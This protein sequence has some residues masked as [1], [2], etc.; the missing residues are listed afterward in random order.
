MTPIG[1]GPLSYYNCA[2]ILHKAADEANLTEVQLLLAHG[3][4]PN[5]PG[6]KV[7]DDQKEPY[8]MT[9]LMA[10]ATSVMS[11]RNAVNRTEIVKRLLEA[12]ADVHAKDSAGNGVIY[13]AVCG[14]RGKSD[15]DHPYP[16]RVSKKA[17]A[18][19]LSMVELLIKA[20]ADVPKDI[21]THKLRSEISSAGRE[22]LALMLL[23]AGAAPL[24]KSENKWTNGW[25]T[26]MVNGIWLSCCSMPAPIRWQKMEGPPSWSTAFGAARLPSGCWMPE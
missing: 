1:Y 19:I 24:A 2:T 10:A 22:K 5:T 12:G 21:L 9:P 4:N 18:D 16:Y 17:E 6:K 20:G 14:G 23:D 11:T 25:T 3:A 15:E 7:K 26:L 13:Y 8:G